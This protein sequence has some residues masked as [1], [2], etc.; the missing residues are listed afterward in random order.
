MYI[1]GS[2]APALPD[3]VLLHG[4]IFLAKSITKLPLLYRIQ[5]SN[6]VQQTTQMQFT[7][8]AWSVA[9]CSFVTWENY[10]EE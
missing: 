9:T 3:H 6:L 4:V 10:L 2:F 8:S 5:M 7:I 1:K